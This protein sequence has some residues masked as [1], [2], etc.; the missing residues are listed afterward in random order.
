MPHEEDTCRSSAENGSKIDY[1]VVHKEIAPYIKEVKVEE[2][3]STLHGLVTLVLNKAPNEQWEYI[4]KRPRA[5]P[6]E[7]QYGPQ[8]YPTRGWEDMVNKDNT[9][10]YHLDKHARRW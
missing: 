10:K 4:A 2:I 1:F 5:F 7:R 3:D 8:R 9:Y 6:E